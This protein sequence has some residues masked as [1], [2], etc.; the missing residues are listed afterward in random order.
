[1]QERSLP[2]KQMLAQIVDES[3]KLP[4]PLR[5][6]ETAY[7]GEIVM[8]DYIYYIPDDEKQEIL[9]LLWPFTP[10]PTLDTEFFDIHEGK[11]FTLKDFR[12]IRWN[13]RNLIVSPYFRSQGGTV[14]DFVSPD[15]ES[16]SCFIRPIKK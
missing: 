2:E 5:R 11:T 12:V 9:E 16:M 6:Y 10:V 4:Y 3:P 7:N 15:A 1:M 8:V 14:L 13:N